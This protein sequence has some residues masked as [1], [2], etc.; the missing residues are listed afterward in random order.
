MIIL[1]TTFLHIYR[2]QQLFAKRFANQFFLLLEF[3][4]A[5]M[6]SDS[7]PHVHEI[8]SLRFGWSTVALW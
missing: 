6:V 4:R 5:G 2:L 3:F 7:S 1:Q 8:R